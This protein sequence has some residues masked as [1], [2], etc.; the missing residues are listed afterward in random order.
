MSEKYEKLDDGG[1]TENLQNKSTLDSDNFA[2]IIKE[3]EDSYFVDLQI[4]MFSKNKDNKMMGRL[5]NGKYVLL[6]K[7]EDPDIITVG[8]P[9]I[10][11][12]R[13]LEKVAFAKIISPVFLPR[14]I[15]RKNIIIFVHKDEGNKI[16]REKFS[17]VN[18]LLEK[19]YELK[20]E[21]FIC[22]LRRED[23]KE[24]PYSVKKL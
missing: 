20:I 22:I 21:K 19:V 13:H 5:D 2:S 12:L 3:K 14:A 15:V 1:D 23:E 18:V 24:N 6:H 7:S 16:I 17:D 4:V 10:C 9:Y 8:L 11:I